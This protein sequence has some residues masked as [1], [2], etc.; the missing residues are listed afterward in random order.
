M[1]NK[2]GFILWNIHLRNANLY[3]DEILTLSNRDFIHKIIS[4]QSIQYTMLGTLIFFR[5]LF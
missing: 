2:T 5:S 3:K 4:N 1:V